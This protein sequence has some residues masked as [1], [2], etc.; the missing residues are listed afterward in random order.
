[1]Y[2][3]NRKKSNNSQKL[4]VVYKTILSRRSIRRYKQKDIPIEIL[5]KLVNAARL[6]PSAANLQ[7]LEYVVVTDK[8]L[9]A[10]IFNTIGW[11]AYITPSW[12]PSIEERPV[13]YIVILVNDLKNKW[14]HRDAGLAS[15]NIVIAE[16]VENA[17]KHVD[18]GGRLEQPLREADVFP[19]V[20]VDMIAIGEEAGKLDLMLFKI[21]ELYDEEVE[22]AINTL[23]SLI[24][25]IL[26]VI[27]GIL[28]G[29]IAAA[30]FLPY[31]ELVNYSG[32]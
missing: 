27:L 16:A 19:D 11:A 4:K 10:E 28:T 1:M 24:Q 7:V 31:F 12:K 21:A 17:Y 2:C 6:S 3:F 32:F 18:S 13:A 20:V 14:Y 15:E 25:P 5:K 8:D 29:V 26:V 23:P 30:M 9:C 22:R